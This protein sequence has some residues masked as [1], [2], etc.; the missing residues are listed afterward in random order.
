VNV[1][2]N[3]AEVALAKFASPAL[4]AVAIQVPAP[5]AVRIPCALMAHPEAV[6]PVSAKETAPVPLPPVVE[7]ATGFP[8]VPEDPE[9]ISVD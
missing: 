7:V 5:V 3:G 2:V 6:P 8:T 1:T 9:K 4:V